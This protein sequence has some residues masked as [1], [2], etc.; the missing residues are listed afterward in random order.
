MWRS[1]SGSIETRP[2]SHFFATGRNSDA[3]FLRAHCEGRAFQCG[4]LSINNQQCFTGPPSASRTPGPASRAGPCS[5]RE[6]RIRDATHRDISRSL[7]LS[8]GPP[9]AA[10][11]VPS[12]PLPP[13]RSLPSAFRRCHPALTRVNV[14]R[15]RLFLPRASR[16]PTSARPA[17][18]ADTAASP[19][20]PSW[21]PAHSKCS[22]R[23]LRSL[24]LSFLINNRKST[25]V[26]FPSFRAAHTPARA[27]A[28][29]P[30]SSPSPRR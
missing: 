16:A 27:A 17:E 23:P 12:T 18:T 14:P 26:N 29:R 30:A 11:L 4:E 25:I 1:A 13:A 19:A 22:L 10:S 8:A 3:P 24:R 5:S 9:L 15:R 2:E 28:S 21:K 20:H 7:A 6:T